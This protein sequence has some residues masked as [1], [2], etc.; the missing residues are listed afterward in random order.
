MITSMYKI[1]CRYGSVVFPDFGRGVS[2][3]REIARA[4]A[5]PSSI[6]LMDNEQFKFGHSLR[7]PSGL[8]GSWGSKAKQVYLTWWKGLDLDRICVATLLFEGTLFIHS[9]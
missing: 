9:F 1:Y 2:C 4:R 7:P 8:I 3:L 6:R 5:Q